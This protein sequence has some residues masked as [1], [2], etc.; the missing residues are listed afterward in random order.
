MGSNS[1]AQTGSAQGGIS[2]REPAR[3]DVVPENSGT[4]GSSLPVLD[5][6]SLNAAQISYSFTSTPPPTAQPHRTELSRP[7]NALDSHTTRTHVAGSSTATDARPIGRVDGSVII[8]PA[9]NRQRAGPSVS[10]EHAAEPPVSDHSSLFESTSNETAVPTT[11]PPGTSSTYD[12]QPDETIG[13]RSRKGKGMVK[14]KTVTGE[15]SKRKRKASTNASTKAPRKRRKRSETPEEAETS[16]IVPST[17]KM[18]DLCKDT[19]KGKKSNRERE[20]AKIDWAEVK[21]KQREQRNQRDQGEVPPQETADQRLERMA[22][23]QGSQTRAVPK[24]RLVN[25]RMV[26]DDQSLQV[27]RHAEAENDAEAH[28]EV[29]ENSLTRRVNCASWMKKEPKETWNEEQT[30]RFYQALRMFGTDFMIISKMFPGRSRRQIK[31]KFTKEERVDPLRIKDAL[32]GPKDP[33]DLEEYQRQSNLECDDPAELQR[34]LEEELKRHEE[35]QKRLE[36]VQQVLQ[37]K[38]TNNAATAAGTGADTDAAAAADASGSA[39]EN[40][41]QASDKTP[42][43]TSKKRASKIVKKGKKGRQKR[44]VGGEEVEILGTID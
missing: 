35:E 16:E 38:R 43:G 15:G 1:S 28:E 18:A 30:D 10:T 29:E 40:R 3:N 26:L 21:R 27:D 42:V 36:E 34:E 23:E 9:S 44:P 2:G 33:M 12:T 22:G 14:Q 24:L 32:V 39:K 8:E 31:L 11:Q 6:H 4:P 17:I 5:S 7:S 13:S 41:G 20:L 37:Q 19:R 25:G